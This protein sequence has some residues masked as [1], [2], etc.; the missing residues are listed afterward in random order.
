M[1]HRPPPAV[2]GLI[3]EP[4][5]DDAGLFYRAG[6]LLERG[7]S[8]HQAYEVWDS[9]QFGRLFRLDGSSMSSERDEFHYHENLVHVPCIAHAGVRRALI[10]GGGDGGSAEELLKQPAI[11]H[12]LIVELDAKVVEIA[13]KY[14]HAVHHGA[15]DDP[16]VELRIG[17]G[18]RHVMELLPTAG[19]RFDLIVLD[20]TE[21]TGPAEAL[22]AEDFFAGCRALLN[23]GGALSLHLGA[24]FF[25]P[26]RVRTLVHR[27][28]AVFSQVR[29]YF[30]YVPLYGTL[31]GFATAA[32]ALDP[33]SLTADE[34][35]LRL[36]RR[37]IGALQHYNGSVHCAQFALPNHLRTLLA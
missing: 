25:Q 7:R 12:V 24:P 30:L 33:A 20:L 10:V 13:R 1:K 28:R 23:P 26:E 31:W 36:L 5:N 22:Y 9:P 18:L 2:E 32:D 8:A 4:L 27:L 14:L 19:Q 34:V 29:P 6:R 15:L 35:D 11:E 3:L 37:G 17:D 16:R 21:P